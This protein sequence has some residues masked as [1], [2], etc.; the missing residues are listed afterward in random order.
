MALKL[1]VSS[2]LF[3]YS[4]KNIEMVRNL[5]STRRMET[6]S[7]FDRENFLVECSI[8][9]LRKLQIILPK[10]VLMTIYKA[11]V[12]PHLDYGDILINQELKHIIL[13]KTRRNIIQC[14]FNYKRDG[15]WHFKR[16]TLPRLGLEFLENRPCIRNLCSFLK[17]FRNR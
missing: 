15:L 1:S 16:K 8:G 10:P 5:L 13:S 17:I 7:I 9:L 3:Q 6:L 4:P 2:G 12:R 14:L 11:F